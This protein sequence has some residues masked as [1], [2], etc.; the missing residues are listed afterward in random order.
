MFD[1]TVHG[2]A[3][4]PDTLPLFIGVA[5]TSIGLVV[6]AVVVGVGGVPEGAT[7]S[8]TATALG[9]G[10]LF[11]VGASLMIRVLYH[12]E[13][14]RTIPVTQTAPIFAALMGVV[15]LGE[16]VSALQWAA[17]V[18][19]VGGAVAI[20]LRGGTSFSG[21]VLHRSFFVLLL[22]AS[23]VAGA[24]VV[25]KVALEELPVLF[26]HGL[27]VLGVGAV[28]LAWSMRR[29]SIRNIAE[30]V[31][32][33]SPALKFVVANE[34]VVANVALLLLLWALSL[35]PVSLVTA[36]AATRAMFVVLYSTTLALVWKGALGEVTT[37]RAV[38][39]KVASTA[40]IVAGVVGIVI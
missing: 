28:Y 12:Q 26:T 19:T 6:V 4:T 13:V 34:L 16:S 35:G 10:A 37:R 27:R 21:V 20:S 24:D 30:L 5:Q 31:R 11:G 32:T 7:L 14:S 25:G 15:F 1:K 38:T 3:R 8:A 40:V 22:G 36:L 29:E 33:R 2:Y 18:A 9:S 39:V 17:I 23:I